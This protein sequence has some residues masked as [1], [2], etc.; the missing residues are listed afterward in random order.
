MHFRDLKSQIKKT[1]PPVLLFNVAIKDVFI[2]VIS[3]RTPEV[4][5]RVRR[6]ETQ[7][8]LG[9]FFNFFWRGEGAQGSHRRKG[10]EKYN[11]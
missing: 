2:L 9:F 8:R 6:G 7:T 5:G 11:P 4:E 10:K 1:C 3:R